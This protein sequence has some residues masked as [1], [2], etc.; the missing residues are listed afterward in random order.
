MYR[1]GDFRAFNFTLISAR[2]KDWER[3]VRA[4]Q[5]QGGLLSAL[6]DMSSGQRVGLIVG[7]AV[8]VTVAAYFMVFKT[9][10]TDN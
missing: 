2:K 7:V 3:F 4:S 10:Q 5:K 8:L 6:A 1:T 9:I